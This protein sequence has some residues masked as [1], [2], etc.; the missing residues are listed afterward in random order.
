VQLT[1]RMRTASII[2]TLNFPSDDGPLRPVLSSDSL[3]ISLVKIAVSAAR[4]HASG[5]RPDVAGCG[6]NPPHALHKQLLL[7]ATPLQ[8]VHP[9][10]ICYKSRFG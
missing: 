7:V 8:C 3:K 9:D 2:S 10:C 1:L 4:H 6:I 5:N